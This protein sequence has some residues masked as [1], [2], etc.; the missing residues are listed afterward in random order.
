MQLNSAYAR[1]SSSAGGL[2]M[3]GNIYCRQKCSICGAKLVHDERRRGFFCTVHPHVMATGGFYIK[4]PGGIRRASKCYDTMMRQLTAMRYETDQDRFDPRMHRPDNPLAFDK[5]AR[6]YIAERKTDP[7]SDNMK[8]QIENKLVQAIAVWGDRPVKAIG[9]REIKHFIKGLTNQRTG[10]PLSNKSMVNYSSVL[11]HFFTKWLVEEEYLMPHEVP[12]FPEIKYE[13]GWR[14]ITTLEKQDEI[15]DVLRERTRHNPKIWFGAELL[16]T[17]PTMRPGDL[18]R[19]KEEDIDLEFGVID[20]PKPTK[21]RG[22]RKIVRLV[23]EHVEVFREFRERYPAMPG[24]PFLRHCANGTNY[25]RDQQM[26]ENCF[27]RWWNRVCDDLGVEGVQLYGGTKHTTTTAT[28]KMLSREAAKAAT[29]HTT[30]KAFLRYCQTKGEEA[31]AVH[32]QVVE[33]RKKKNSGK[34]VSLG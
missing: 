20:M 8:R 7:I 31:L 21:G 30:D 26:G 10:K 3:D 16:R 19:M 24:M 18:H 5:L 29:G 14:K 33:K 2:C 15:L 6:V 4:F 22:Q 25:K 13:L 32:Q 12:A 27:R 11:H 34:V 28:A 9:R 23:D 1:A 17:Y